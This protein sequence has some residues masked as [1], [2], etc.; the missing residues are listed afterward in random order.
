MPDQSIKVPVRADV[1]AAVE[2]VCEAVNI[3]EEHVGPESL[4]EDQE[5]VLAAARDLRDVAARP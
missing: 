2:K 1:I 4:A 3:S 5:R